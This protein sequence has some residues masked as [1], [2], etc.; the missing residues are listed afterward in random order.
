MCL[1]KSFRDFTSTSTLEQL[2]EVQET[3]TY[4]VDPIIRAHAPQ[5]G[6]YL[7]EADFNSPYWKEDFD[8]VNYNTLLAIKDKYDPNRLLCG[9]LAVAVGDRWSVQDDA[10]LCPV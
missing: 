2:Q 6:A 1:N 7:N 5:G 3:V 9:S 10:R 8:G 4:K